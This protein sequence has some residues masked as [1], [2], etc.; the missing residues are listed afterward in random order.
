MNKEMAMNMLK[1]KLYLIE[2]EK[3]EKKL[4]D[5]VG[6]K[7]KRPFFDEEGNC[8]MRD[9]IDLGLTVDERIAD[10]YYF[11]KTVRLLKKLLENPELLEQTLETE[12]DY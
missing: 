7:K 6:E 4:N 3:R 10:G 12:V 2:L 5:I 8:E 1:A 11:S 9:S